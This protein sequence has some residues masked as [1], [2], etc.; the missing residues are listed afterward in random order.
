MIEKKE[1]W[2]DVPGVEGVYQASN[3][4]RVRSLDRTVV[5]KDGRERFYKGIVIEGSVHKGYRK[6]KLSVNGKCKVFNTSQI[7]AMTFLDHTPDGHTK[8]IDHKNGDRSD[9]R[10][11]NLRIVTNRENLSN[12]CF[13]KDSK[14]LSSRFTGVSWHKRAEKYRSSI[15]YE[16][17]LIFLGFYDNE[18]EASKSYQKALSEINNGVFNP[19]GYK[20][21]FTSKHK[22][23]YFNKQSN[24]WMSRVRVNGKQKYLGIFKTELEAHH[25]YQKAL[26][27]RHHFDV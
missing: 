26:K 3:M 6:I 23:V 7:I 24:K 4:G 2:K 9:D 19:D 22:G 1:I 18:L 5:Y 17:E 16:G 12:V 15:Q 11:E 10:V 14:T 13:R 8:V 25:A 27:E 21:S 20:P